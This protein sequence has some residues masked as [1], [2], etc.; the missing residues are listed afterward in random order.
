[1]CR[2]KCVGANVRSTEDGRCNGCL[3]VCVIGDRVS[4]ST[5]KLVITNSLSAL[6]SYQQCIIVVSIT[7]HHQQQQQQLTDSQCRGIVTVCQTKTPIINQSINQ[8]WIY[9]L[10]MLFLAE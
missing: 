4:E 10:P 8:S 9:M 7:H 3:G 5:S 2:G 6:Q 1:M